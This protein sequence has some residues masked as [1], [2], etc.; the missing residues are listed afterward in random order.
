MQ[1][2]YHTAFDR[3]LRPA[4]QSVTIYVA[5]VGDCGLLGC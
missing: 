4:M 3:M 5:H 2:R 1:K